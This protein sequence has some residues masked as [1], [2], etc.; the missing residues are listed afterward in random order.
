MAA[1]H[2]YAMRYVAQHERLALSVRLLAVYV[3][4]FFAQEDFGI[5]S[6]FKFDRHSSFAYNAA[7]AGRAGSE[8]G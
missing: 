3:V 2:G 8:V 5:K 4:A 7:L 6:R 1:T